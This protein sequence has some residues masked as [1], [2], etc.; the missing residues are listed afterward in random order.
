M[1]DRSREFQSLRSYNYLS[2]PIVM[3]CDPPE[4]YFHEI[5]TTAQSLAP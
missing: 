3:V 5:S 4:I 1:H 2:L